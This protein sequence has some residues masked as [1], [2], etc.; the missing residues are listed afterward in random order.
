MLCILACEISVVIRILCLGKLKER[1]AGSA[2]CTLLHGLLSLAM[3]GHT[4]TSVARV[5]GVKGLGLC[6]V[7]CLGIWLAGVRIH[8]DLRFIHVPDAWE[9][10]LPLTGATRLLIY[11]SSFY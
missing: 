9:A 4:A 10:L 2:D 1:W 5:A 6:Q 8:V 7:S 3:W 11:L